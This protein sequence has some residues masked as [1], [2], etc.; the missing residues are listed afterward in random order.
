MG[1]SAEEI[2]RRRGVIHNGNTTL[3]RLELKQLRRYLRRRALA[4]RTSPLH[5]D[6]STIEDDDAP[7]SPALE[8]DPISQMEPP[9]P[10]RTPLREASPGC[11]PAGNLDKMALPPIPT[12]TRTSSPERIPVDQSQDVPP[13]PDLGLTGH[14]T[15]GS[16]FAHRSPSPS[17]SLTC[18][19]RELETA[20]P[21]AD[22]VNQKPPQPTNTTEALELNVPHPTSDIFRRGVLEV[23]GTNTEDLEA[24]HGLCIRTM[25]I[26]TALLEKVLASEF[27]WIKHFKTL[28]DFIWQRSQ[29]DGE[30]RTAYDK[31]ESAYFQKRRTNFL[32][33]RSEVRSSVKDAFTNGLGVVKLIE[34]VPQKTVCKCGGPG[35]RYEA[36]DAFSASVACLSRFPASLK[37]KPHKHERGG[38]T[39]EET[40][41]EAGQT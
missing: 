4:Q 1:L 20:G 14:F 19:L 10:A 33:L 6:T 23:N 17:D 31:I 24:R 13:L 41:Q 28:K 29:P 3:S 21:T 38:G 27:E 35:Q 9:C 34:P 40:N 30:L 36:E 2:L 8:C 7:G 39:H 26:Q 15:Q 11:P 18:S 32:D 25:E 37:R 22:S 16:P 12:P 5:S